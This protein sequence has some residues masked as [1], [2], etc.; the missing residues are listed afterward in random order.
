MK[1]LPFTLAILTLL[2]LA[3][4][5]H[6]DGAAL[7]LSCDGDSN[8]ANVTINGQ[9]KGEC[10]LDVQVA[11]GTFQIRAALPV[12]KYKER[13]FEQVIRLGDG[14][15]K[16]VDIQLGAPQFTAEGQR[17]E[18]ERL[19]QEAE[20]ARKVTE[21]TRLAQEE[22]HRAQQE[23][24]TKVLAE[25]KSQGIEP[26][27]GKRFRDCDSCPELVLIPP[28]EKMP[29][30]AYVGITSMDLS[31]ALVADVVVDSPAEKAGI[32][33]NDTIV[34]IN[35]VKINSFTDLTNYI[36]PLM[37]GA[38]VN[39]I[40]Q[41]GGVNKNIS[42]TTQEAPLSAPFFVGAYPITFDEWD[43]CKND[44][45]CRNINA[46]QTVEKGILI[47]QIKNWGR[48][49]QPVIN[50]G[51][52]DIQIYIAW[53]NKKTG[54]TYHLLTSN[55]WIHACKGEANSTYCG[56]ENLD[57]LAWYSGNSAGSTHPVGQKLPN[58]YGLYDM[59]GN[60]WELLQ[61][62]RQN[63]R[64]TGTGRSCLSWSFLGGSWKTDALKTSHLLT[65]KDKKDPL[66]SGLEFL[67]G[68]SGASD[69]RGFR[70]ARNLQ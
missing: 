27:N 24:L 23:R 39:I 52:D 34:Q 45:V 36:G 40:V 20:R 37:P 32:L 58:S 62:C 66:Y 22:A 59:S 53:L 30:R 42:M 2:T 47:D 31:T 25:L 13:I 35:D 50:L 16:R 70:L 49:R 61:D 4:P 46:G 7:R 60:V 14:V 11:A 21:A 43:V 69:D 64:A 19:A 41:R 5:A 63:D 15:V 56:G 38:L 67:L 26:G 17:L 44:G 68:A 28:R 29:G 57:S 12:N 51:W 48:G 8:G 10:P 18:N 9:F 55:E 54:R 65:I 6:A 3:C 33:P 1:M